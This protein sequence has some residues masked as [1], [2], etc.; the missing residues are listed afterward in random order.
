MAGTSKPSLFRACRAVAVVASLAATSC[1]PSSERASDASSQPPSSSA[2]L[3]TALRSY[4][5]AFLRRNPTTNTYLGGAG[6]DPSLKDVDGALRDHSAAA[7]EQEDRWLAETS[8]AIESIDP[9]S[10][11]PNGRIDREVA[12]AQIRFILRQHQT[13]RYQERALDTYTSE[14]FRAIDWQLQG[15]TQTGVNTYGTT[16]EWTLLITRVRAIPQFLAT[17]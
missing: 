12:L 15:M 7:L 6:L 5:V 9:A 10:L 16:E 2:A 4:A 14:P 3:T 1:S 8:N 17:A 13:R 11:S